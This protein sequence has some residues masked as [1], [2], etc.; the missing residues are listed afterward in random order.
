[1]AQPKRMLAGVARQTPCEVEVRVSCQGPSKHPRAWGLA[2]QIPNGKPRTFTPNAFNSLRK[3]V[4][5][6]GNAC[7]TIM[8]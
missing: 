3:C 5:A 7:A 1:M 4:I 2:A 8:Y 6:R